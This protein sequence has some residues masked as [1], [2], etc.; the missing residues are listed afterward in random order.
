MFIVDEPGPAAEVDGLIRSALT[1]E[2]IDLPGIV[3]RARALAGAHRVWTARFAVGLAERRSGRKE[4][5]YRAFEEVLGLAPGC[6]EAHLEL[7]LLGCEIDRPL[8]A[9][10]HAERAFELAG[11]SREVLLALARALA[12]GGQHPE[13]RL[14]IARIL[15]VRPDDA[16]ARALE[17]ALDRMAG[18]PRASLGERIARSITERFKR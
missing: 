7:S 10:A 14:V 15:S 5:A 9:I 1:A 8:D 16:D 12:L 11:E 6:A 13:A 3:A 4:E 2:P 17:L 18:A